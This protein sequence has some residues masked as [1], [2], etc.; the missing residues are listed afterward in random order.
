MD[1]A[2]ACLADPSTWASAP[3][4]NTV[5]RIAFGSGGT[6]GTT[7]D[8]YAGGGSSGTQVTTYYFRRTFMM[9]SAR[10]R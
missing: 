7:I 8:R 6:F 2:E 9:P 1:V 10:S 3:A 5:Q 4:T